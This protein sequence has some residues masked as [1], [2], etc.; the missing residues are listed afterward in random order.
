M[1]IHSPFHF[2]EYF[3]RREPNQFFISIIFREFALGLVMIFEPIYL[4][5]YFGKSIS[6]TLLFFALIHGF[7]SFLAVFGGRIMAKV[8]FN[9]AILFSHF[10]FFLYFLSLFSV[11][12]SIF[13][14]FL[15]IIF[16]VIGKTLFWPSFHTDFVRFSSKKHRASEVA[17]LN[18]ASIAP[19]VFSPIIGG[20]ILSKFG[21]SALFATTLIVLLFSAVPLFLSKKQSEVYADSY[22]NAWQ[23]IFRK[24]NRKM[25][26]SLMSC[27]GEMAIN[28]YLWPLF[29]FV[30]LIKYSMIGALTSFAI[31]FSVLFNLYVGK[32]SDTKNRLKFL[33]IGALLTSFSWILKY[34][35][36]TPLNALLAQTIYRM[37][38]TSASVPLR[39]LFYD[40]AVAKKADADEFIIYRIIIIHLSKFFVLSILAILFLFTNQIN[41]SFILAIIF[42]L[43]LMF[44]GKLSKVK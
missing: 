36:L 38:R 40:I 19:V 7:A 34:F 16:N 24:R 42:S 22:K 33:N 21:Y 11:Y 23:R 18:I 9:R 4:Y 27:S 17:N 28:D 31:A 13:F 43:G 12:K 2:L 8:G 39:A 41:L 30:L 29:M 15:A 1:S 3:L 32:I 35:V 25:N 20:L 44:F 6:L 5:L 26:L 10:F 14:I 37:S